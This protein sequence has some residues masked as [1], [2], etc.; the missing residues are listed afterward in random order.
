MFATEMENQVAARPNNRLLVASAGILLVLF[1]E[2]VFSI[3]L[4]Q[5]AQHQLLSDFDKVVS[6]AATAVGQTTVSPLPD[7][8]PAYGSPV[9]LIQIPKLNLTQVVVEGSTSNFTQSGPGHVPGTVLPGQAGES[10]IIGRRTSFGAPFFKIGDLKN[11]DVIKV[12]TVE[13]PSIYKVIAAKDAEANTGLNTLKLVTSNP[14]ILATGSQSVVAQLQAKPYPDT[15]RNSRIAPNSN[16]FALMLLV[17]QILAILL[18]FTRGIYRKFGPLIGWMLLTPLLA[19]TLLAL[20][21]TF[22]T[23]LPATL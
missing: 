21:L 11:G 4:Q 7:T 16:Q 13:G 5:R 10:V 12:T 15:P 3:L 20:T 17:L 2:F 1:I 14:P 22:D 9:A 8:A 23:L 18:Y 6:Q 19:A